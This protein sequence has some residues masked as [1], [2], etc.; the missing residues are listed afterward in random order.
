MR[1]PQL[2][3]HVYCVLKAFFL[4]HDFNTF[5]LRSQNIFHISSKLVGNVKTFAELGQAVRQG[6]NTGAPGLQ[7]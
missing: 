5:M 7:V 1:L 4:R 6:L 2:V 3:E